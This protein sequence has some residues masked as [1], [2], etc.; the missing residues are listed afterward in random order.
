MAAWFNIVSPGQL[1]LLSHSG[2]R[3]LY[4]LQIPEAGA[5][6]EINAHLPGLTASRILILWLYVAPPAPFGLLHSL[7]LTLDYG[8]G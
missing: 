6:Q 7:F 4:W 8:F 5:Q 1:G 2:A 3:S